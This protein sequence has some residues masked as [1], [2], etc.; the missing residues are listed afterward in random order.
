MP[1]II[2]KYFI[3]ALAVATTSASLAHA[4]TPIDKM[5]STFRC[6]LDKQTRVL[7]VRLN[8]TTAIAY[9]TGRCKMIKLWK[10]EKG[11]LINLTGPVYN[12]RHG[13]QPLSIGKTVISES[14][15]LF[16]STNK[17]EKIKLQYKGYKLKN[18]KNSDQQLTTLIYE[19]S[20]SSGKLLATIHESPTLKNSKISRSF[21]LK[22]EPNAS[23]NLGNS[24][25]L[26]WT[27]AK[28]GKKLAPTKVSKSMKFTLTHS[29]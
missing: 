9:D 8:K 16:S 10:D 18:L 2:T 19:V 28:T 26:N 15:P 1:K 25:S 5:P 21:D 27:V 17:S 23:I 29:L 6:V 7:V 11:Q 12:G 14:Q 13:E 22:L 20:D 3:S 24:E 4:G